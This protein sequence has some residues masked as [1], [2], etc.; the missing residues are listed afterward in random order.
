MARIRTIKPEFF[1][2]ADI[3]WLSPLARLLYI[4]VWC[5]ADKEGRL[6]WSPRTFKLRY[7]PGDNCDID[8]LCNELVASRLVVL[9]GD[10][11][12]HIPTF[13]AH[14][15][16]NPRESV[17]QLPEPTRV[18]R[19]PTRQP[20]V[21][22]AQG[23]REGKG[24]EGKDKTAAVLP[25]GFLGFWEVW[26]NNAR[27]AAKKQCLDKW[28]SHGCEAMAEAVIAAVVAAKQ[29]DA[30]KKDGGQYIPA[31]LVWLN[32]ARWEAPVAAAAPS[33]APPLYVHEAPLSSEEKAAANEARLRALSSVKRL[34]A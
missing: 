34:H 12:A 32:Q 21:V 23:G 24:K 20:R 25:A 17:S 4:A 14:Q 8:A 10:G 9:Y 18:A 1:T 28:A 31:P 7:L 26:P 33:H 2:S 22:D 19:V 11:L 15:H 13:K 3:V 16:V 27:K 30:W 29:S 5:E 6:V